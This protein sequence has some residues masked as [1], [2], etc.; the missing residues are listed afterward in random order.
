MAAHH[1]SDVD[2]MRAAVFRAPGWVE[3][4]E[5][6]APVPAAGEARVRVAFCGVCGSDL[7]RF[8]GDLPLVS[9]TPGH[10]ISG[11]VDSVG[12]GVTSIGP[13]DKVCVEPLVPCGAC[14][15]CRTGHHQLCAHA[16]YLAADVDGGFAEYVI[17]P[18]TMVHRLPDTIPLEQAALM[19]PLAVAV[20]AARQGGVGPGSSVCVLGAGTIGLLAVQVARA[21][22]ASQVMITAKHAHQAAAAKSLG[23][24]SVIAADADVP[25][26]VVRLTDGEGVDCV[27]ETVGGHAP[28]PALAMDIARKHGNVVI[29]GGFA[30]PQP[31]DFRQ[32]VMKELRIL[33]SHTYDYG[34]NMQRDFEVALGLVASGRVRLG[35]FTKHRFPLDRIQDACQAAVSKDDNLLKALIVC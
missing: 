26:E 7:H 2:R 10:E 9:V 13:G 3:V 30:S 25:A 16:H 4:H 22:G 15:Y 17:V 32:L 23:A 28:T 18:A 5:V 21:Y 24:D 31:V 8:R 27:M 34:P 33:G 19:E 14:R 20:H 11:I 12:A 35:D 1:S 29:V 6:A